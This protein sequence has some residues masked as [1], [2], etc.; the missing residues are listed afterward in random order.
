MIIKKSLKR[1]YLIILNP[2]EIWKI[3]P[4]SQIALYFILAL[5]AI[6][7]VWYEL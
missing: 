2:M 5:I 3:L 1:D 6:K 4:K 7:T